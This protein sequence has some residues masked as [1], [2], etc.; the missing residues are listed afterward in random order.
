ME[1]SKRPWNDWRSHIS[2]VQNSTWFIS[3]FWK[4]CLYI[5]ILKSFYRIFVSKYWKNEAR[6]IL[7]LTVSLETKLHWYIPAKCFAFTYSFLFV[8]ADLLTWRLNPFHVNV[9]FLYPLKRL[10][11]KTKCFLTF[12]G[13][14]RNRTLAWKGLIHFMSMLHFYTPWKRQ[15]TSRFLFSGAIEMEYWFR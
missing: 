5:L 12:S 14:Y 9:L 10:E 11:N 13:G 2:I 8:R 6:C 1:S 4:Y 15:K 7:F 3:M